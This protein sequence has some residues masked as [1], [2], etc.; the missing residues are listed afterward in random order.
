M[1]KIIAQ[2]TKSQRAIDRS[3]AA[4]S[5]AGSGMARG[6]AVALTVAS[7]IAAEKG[8]QCLRTGL[9]A[10]PRGGRQGEIL[11]PA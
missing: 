5:E 11:S 7:A 3:P 8:R 6:A 1:A 9:L 4:R 2:Q 10:E